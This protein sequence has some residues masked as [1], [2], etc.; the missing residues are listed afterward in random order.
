MLP[1]PAATDAIAAAA[2]ST[3]SSTPKRAMTFVWK[4]GACA[5]HFHANN[6]DS[7]FIIIVYIYIHVDARALTTLLMRLTKRAPASKAYNNTYCADVSIPVTNAIQRK[8][9]CRLDLIQGG[10]CH[11]SA[12]KPTHNG[13]APITSETPII[14]AE[15]MVMKG[16]L[17]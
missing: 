16:R 3:L 8:V 15:E 6:N 2:F 4:H 1:P 10:D 12:D 11:Q 9:Q 13:T 5:F 7:T 14:D 17:W